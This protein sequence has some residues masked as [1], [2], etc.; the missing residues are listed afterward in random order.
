M[1]GAME[2]SEMT[3]RAVNLVSKFVMLGLA[4]ALAGPIGA[5]ETELPKAADML[6][7]RGDAQVAG[8]RNI[9]RIFPVRVVKRGPKVRPLPGADQQIAPSL[10]YHVRPVS[11]D[12]FVSREGIAGLP[13][14]SQGKDVQSGRDQVYSQLTN[15]P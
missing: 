3:L 7:W 12:E 15:S 11:I 14:I 9:D 8:F 6:R 13:L 1:S 4:L 2:N 5:K 10:H